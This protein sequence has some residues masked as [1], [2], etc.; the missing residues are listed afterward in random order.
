[1]KK[2]TPFNKVAPAQLTQ[3]RPPRERQ[4][5][6]AHPPHTQPPRQAIQ[7][8]M[9]AHPA[10]RPPPHPHAP[11][12][13]AGVAPPNAA[14]QT[15]GQRPPHAPNDARTRAGLPCCTQAHPAARPGANNPVQPKTFMQSRPARPVPPAA[16]PPTRFNHH[17]EPPS[18]ATPGPERGQTARPLRT[19][20]TTPARPGAG[21]QL[22]AGV[23]NT[24]RPPQAGP[25]AGPRQQQVLQRHTAPGSGLQPGKPGANPRPRALT[26]P[27]P[28]A[29][30][31][32][33]PAT[34]QM[35]PAAKW[36]ISRTAGGNWYYFRVSDIWV[37]LEGEIFKHYNEKLKK[38]LKKRRKSVTMSDPSSDYDA[39]T[40]MDQL[41]RP[42]EVEAVHINKMGRIIKY[43]AHV[44]AYGNPAPIKFDNKEFSTYVKDRVHAVEL[45]ID[46]KPSSYENVVAGIKETGGT[47]EK[48]ARTIRRLLKGYETTKKSEIVEDVRLERAAAVFGVAETARNPATIAH[49]LTVLHLVKKGEMTWDDMID[50]SKPGYY[51]PHQDGASAKLQELRSAMIGKLAQNKNIPTALNDYAAP[52]RHNLKQFLISAATQYT[53]EI[54]HSATHADCV[55]VSGSDEDQAWGRVEKILTDKILKHVKT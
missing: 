50:T 32:H 31:P 46:T 40:L 2:P 19:S 42:Q 17:P 54:V 25:A 23:P 36:A 15:V 47:A 20:P 37:W 4:R 33:R 28:S 39:M 14:N 26:L 16:P 48:K 3:A 52:Y 55:K 29:P 38:A 21:V 6:P 8:K 18:K 22:K 13:R 9:P 34:V 51:I 30:A 41:R 5:V 1:M 45:Y 44:E 11:A 27:E 53:G 35:H 49:L 10:H 12:P 43:A 24:L 7:A